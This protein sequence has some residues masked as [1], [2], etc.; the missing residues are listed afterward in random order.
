ML[1]L[2]QLADQVAEVFS[3]KL[4]I[5]VPAHDS[6]LIEIGAIDSLQ[7]VELLFQLEQQL[8]MRISLE[9]IDFASA[10]SLGSH[11]RWPTGRVTG[12]TRRT[13]RLQSNRIRGQEFC[14]GYG[15]EP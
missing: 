11:R 10:A 9:E 12:E 1:D 15:R 5:D 4:H 6:D 8:G 2:K 14:M 3:E 13:A 7:L